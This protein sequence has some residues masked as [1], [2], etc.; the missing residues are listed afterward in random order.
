M[1]CQTTCA[2]GGGINTTIINCTF[3][4]VPK[5]D[6]KFRCYAVQGSLGLRPV[7]SQALKRVNQ[8]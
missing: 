1:L 5:C 8:T 7:L 2:I 4:K 6:W 3:F